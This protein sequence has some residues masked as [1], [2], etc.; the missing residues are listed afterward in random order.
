MEE[1]TIDIAEKS[2]L[3]MIPIKRLYKYLIDAYNLGRSTKFC[4]TGIGDFR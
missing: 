1:N 3:F 2:E 4:N